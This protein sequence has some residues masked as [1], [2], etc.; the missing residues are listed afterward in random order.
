MLVRAGSVVAPLHATSNKGTGMGS[1]EALCVRLPDCAAAT[2]LPPP[3]R[4]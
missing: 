2:R 4:V 1:P 3:T